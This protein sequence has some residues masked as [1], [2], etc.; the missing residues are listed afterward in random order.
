M[1]QSCVGRVGIITLVGIMVLNSGL[2]L[3][4]DNAGAAPPNKSG[5]SSTPTQNW[6]E[7]RTGAARFTVLGAFGNA[8]VRDN[9]TGL[10]WEQSPDLTTRTWVE[11]T[12]Y[13]VNKTVGGTKGWRLPSVVELASMIDP[14]L[15]APFVPANVFNGVQSAS[16]W[17]ATTF[18]VGTPPDSSWLLD[19]SLGIAPTPILR[20]NP[21]LVWCVRGPMNADTY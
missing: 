3:M 16:Y 1:R 14:S 9:N 20:A 19:F 4:V 15:I 6:D 17:S 7:N 18:A 12:T 21:L 10:V 11:A 8:A 2:F 13:C 5:S